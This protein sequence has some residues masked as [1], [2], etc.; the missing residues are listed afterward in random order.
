MSD[1]PAPDE[2][3]D[4]SEREPTPALAPDATPGSAAP[5][6]TPDD[7]VPDDAPETMALHQVLL[8]P[9]Y[10]KLLL[11]CVLLGAPIAL[12]CF[13]FVSLQYELQHAVWES[14]PETLGYDHAPW[15]WPLPAL[16]LG[17][18]LLV[19]IVTRLKGG[20]GHLPVHGLGGGEPATPGDVP[21]VAL[22][23]LAT[24]PLGTVLGPEA[25]L[26][27]VGSGLAL[28]AIRRIQNPDPRAKTVLAAAGSTTA[29]STILGGPLVAAILVIESAGIAGP[30]LVALLLPCLLASATGALIFTG[31]GQWTGL[32]TGA[33][34]LPSVPPDARP[35]LGDFLWGI[36]LAA[37]VAVLLVLGRSLGHRVADWVAPRTASRTVICAL[38]VGSCLSAYALLTGRSPD[39]ASLSGQA[40]LGELAAHPHALSLAALTALVLCKGLAWS[41]CLAAFRGGPIFPAIMLGAAIALACAGLPGLG[42]T[43]ALALGIA[44]ATAAI[45]G[46][47][48]C[49]VVLTVLLLGGEAHH[50]M[51]LIVVASVVAV[52]V[53][54]WMKGRKPASP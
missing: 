23:A 28:L 14:L 51:P 27:A 31:F 54:Q 18:L 48:L 37:L 3:P 7:P 24:L 25:P 8:A 42:A 53:A 52:L 19:P 50:Q 33:L 16:L 32:K 44:A 4:G 45:T 38:A 21:G 40:M 47:P 30:Q 17:G 10:R 36:P 34:S 20:G 46:L 2:A 12:A 5:Q 39:E 41:I 26:M 1:E 11:L 35:D 43:P 49:S 6:A 29:I 9:G 22:A 15:W 13:F